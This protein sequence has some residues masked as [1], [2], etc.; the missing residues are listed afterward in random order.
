MLSAW[1]IRNFLIRQPLA[2]EIRLT[3]DGECQMVARSGKWTK[4]AETI[5]ALEPELIELLD[6][7]GAV[8]RACRPAET[9][10]ASES[11]PEAPAVLAADPNAAMLT[12][13]SN[14]LHRAYE[15]STTVAFT[16]MV[17][18][19]EH[20]NARA[21]AIERRLERS[22][23]AYRRVVQQQIDDAYERA[24][25]LTEAALEQQQDATTELSLPGLVK[26]FVSSMGQAEDQPSAP[27]NGKGRP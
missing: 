2:H 18:L 9:Q 3:R 12:H 17:E 15:H 20:N 8:I 11:A 1:S 6:G 24:D 4:V 5:R 14:L 25:E 19:F 7:D 26:T 10:D 23:A 22:E 21:D 13:F 16:K 27:S